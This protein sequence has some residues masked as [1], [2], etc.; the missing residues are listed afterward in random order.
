MNRSVP[1]K[2]H[3][4]GR[5]RAPHGGLLCGR[6]YSSQRRKRRTVV[7]NN[8]INLKKLKSKEK[9]RT[10]ADQFMQAFRPLSVPTSIENQILILSPSKVTIDVPATGSTFRVNIGFQSTDG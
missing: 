9:N 6:R 1:H 10:R 3:D 8:F 4:S 5:D 7:R 2:E